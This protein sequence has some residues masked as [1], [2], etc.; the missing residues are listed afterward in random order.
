MAAAA[1][2]AAAAAD[3]AAV[4]CL[5]AEQAVPCWRS[6]T[7]PAWLDVAAAAAAAASGLQSLC[8]PVL[9]LA[10]AEAGGRLWW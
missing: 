5:C 1:A 2:A 6:Q 4:A 10:S 3:S 8:C 7:G 9:S